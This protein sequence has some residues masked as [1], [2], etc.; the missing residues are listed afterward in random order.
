MRVR[1]PLSVRPRDVP[2]DVARALNT[3]CDA[4]VHLSTRAQWAS[5]EHKDRLAVARDA[6]GS[7]V[8]VLW[9]RAE[10]RRHGRVARLL[11]ARSHCVEREALAEE[12]EPSSSKELRTGA[13]VVVG[14]YVLATRQ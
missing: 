2:V 3:V 12:V 11:T 14:Q 9:D 10:V 7:C 6:S 4:R 5:A 13:R 8:R 1:L